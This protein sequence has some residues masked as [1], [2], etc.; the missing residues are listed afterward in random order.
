MSR[1]P[2]LITQAEVARAIR[3]AKAEGAAAVEIERDGTIR[4]ILVSRPSPSTAPAEPVD[5][6]GEIVL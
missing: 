6:G 2:A 1:R 4:V 3:A 5:D